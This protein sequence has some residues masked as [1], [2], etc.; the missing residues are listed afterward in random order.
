MCIGWKNILTLQ[1]RLSILP[2]I[3]N[4]KYSP[5]GKVTTAT[6]MANIILVF[7]L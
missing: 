6:T 1:K 2:P 5:S 3:S 4:L 7:C